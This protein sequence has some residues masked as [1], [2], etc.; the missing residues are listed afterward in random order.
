VLKCV[1]KGMSSFFAA[2]T[3]S[4]FHP[5]IVAW[6]ASS[7]KHYCIIGSSNLSRAAFSANYEANIFSPISAREFGRICKWIDEIGMIP[8]TEEWITGHYQ[9][10]KPARRNKAASAPIQIKARLLPKSAACA[11]SVKNKRRNQQAFAGVEQKLRKLFI[12]CSSDRANEGRFWQQFWPLYKG[13][14]SWRLQGKG[15]EI[16][17]KHARWP[18]ACGALV[19]IL[20]AAKTPAINQLD[21]VVAREIDDLA[22]A[23]NSVRGAWLSEMLCHYLPLLYPVNNKPVQKW[24]SLNAFPYSRGAKEGK[25]YVELAQKLRWVLRKYHP[26]GARNLAEMDGAIHSRLSELGLL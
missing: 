17:A 25:R 5:K 14:P 2:D 4:G 19:R 12:Q 20:E 18:Q 21:G 13:H 6:K 3:E 8:I 10:A 24:W 16:T 15:L 26:A 9:E 23:G 1:P 7:G 22:K 11:Q